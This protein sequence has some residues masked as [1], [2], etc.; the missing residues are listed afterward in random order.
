MF[1]GITCGQVDTFL[2]ESNTTWIDPLYLLSGWIEEIPEL[3]TVLHVPNQWLRSRTTHD[4]VWYG[5]T[6]DRCQEQW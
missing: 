1:W 6:L 5:R 2:V 3:T 4:D